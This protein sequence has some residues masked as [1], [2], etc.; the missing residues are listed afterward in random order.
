VIY[1]PPSYNENIFKTIKNVLVM[2]DGQNLFDPS[3]CFAGKCWYVQKTINQLVTSG[4]MEEVLV[5]GINNSPDRINEYTY[6]YDSEIKGGGKGDLYLDFIEKIVLPTIQTNYR[7]VFK[8][9]NLGILG[10]SLGGLISCYAGWTRSSIYGR[11][12]CM[13]SSFFW[14]KMDF[15]NTI[16]TTKS[17]PLPDLTIYLDSGNTGPAQDDMVE[18]MTVRDTIQ[19]IGRGHYIMNKNLFYYLDKGGQ[20]SEEYWAARF[21]IPMSAFYPA[22]A[23]NTY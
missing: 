4:N 15:N 18:T 7:A 9:E 16:L 2:H 6:S 8:K 10:S 21:H 11:S 19:A 17:S 20:H 5:V 22:T 3:L 23:L 14:N 13:S 12:G 1:T